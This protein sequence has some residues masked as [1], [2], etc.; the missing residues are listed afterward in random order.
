MGLIR[1]CRR[2]RSKNDRLDRERESA[3]QHHD[4]SAVIVAGFKRVRDLSVR[5]VSELEKVPNARMSIKHVV[6][7]IKKMDENDLDHDATKY[8]VGDL[9]IEA[10]ALV[11]SLSKPR[12]RSD[13]P[14]TV[15]TLIG[16]VIA[17]SIHLNRHFAASARTGVSRV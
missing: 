3:Q 14:D 12:V 1:A 10:F 15:N 16:Q 11:L 9:E 2:T 6:D 13:V 17:A 5:L 4:T 8:C 7:R